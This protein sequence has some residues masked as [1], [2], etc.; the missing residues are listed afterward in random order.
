MKTFYI[1]F[2][3]RSPFRDGWVEVQAK[4][5]DDAFEK[6]REAMGS[7]YATCYSEESFEPQYFPAGK[8]GRTIS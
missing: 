4:D 7:M 1:T 8:L 3:H 2:G 6:A 5:L